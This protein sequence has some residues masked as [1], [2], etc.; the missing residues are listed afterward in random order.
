MFNNYCYFYLILTSFCQEN[1]RVNTDISAVCWSAG[2]F[3]QIKFNLSL[4][5]VL[6]LSKDTLVKH[7]PQLFISSMCSQLRKMGSVME[8]F[9]KVNFFWLITDVVQWNHNITKGQ[10]QAT[11]R[12]CLLYKVA[13]YWG[14]FSYLLLLLGYWKSFVIPRTSIFRGLFHWGSTVASLLMLWLSNSVSKEHYNYLVFYFK[15]EAA[16]ILFDRCIFC[17]FWKCTLGEFFY[18]AMQN[19]NFQNNW[20]HRLQKEMRKKKVKEIKN[21]ILTA[22]KSSDYNWFK[23]KF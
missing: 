12:I 17:D 3:S 22:G 4:D 16:M 8:Q 2:A 9:S 18:F 20:R 14:S 5:V 1:K 10:G 23:Y 11:G 15:C 19:V 7:L 21:K 13:L 6:S